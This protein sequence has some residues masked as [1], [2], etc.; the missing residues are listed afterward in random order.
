MFYL[1]GLKDGDSDAFYKSCAGLVKTGRRTGE[2]ILWF[3]VPLVNFVCRQYN[4]PDG[5]S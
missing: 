5:R 4:R 2:N 1:N 3:S